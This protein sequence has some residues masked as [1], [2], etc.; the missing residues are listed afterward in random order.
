VAVLKLYYSISSSSTHNWYKAQED[1]SI[2]IG[3]VT[4]LKKKLLSHLSTEYKIPERETCFKWAKF[5]SAILLAIIFREPQK[6][7][8][9]IFR[10]AS[11]S[12]TF[13]RHQHHM[14]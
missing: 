8:S 1:T 11:A 7:S 13:I 5:S 4:A 6:Q 2:N 14:K 9:A 3:Q 10:T 12:Y